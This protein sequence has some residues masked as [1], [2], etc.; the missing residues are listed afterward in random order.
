MQNEESGS[1]QD[2]NLGIENIRILSIRV[3]RDCLRKGS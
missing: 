3:V 1:I 2:L